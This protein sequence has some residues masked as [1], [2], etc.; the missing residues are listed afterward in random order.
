MFVFLYKWIRR[1]PQVA[2]HTLRW[3]VHPLPEPSIGTRRTLS[4]LSASPALTFTSPRIF[5]QS[6]TDR[7]EPEHAYRRMA[8]PLRPGGATGCSRG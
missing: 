5:Q 7:T 1:L 3:G 2:P 6:A 8:H 4:V